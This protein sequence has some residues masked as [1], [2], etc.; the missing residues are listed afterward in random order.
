MKLARGLRTRSYKAAWSHD[1][2]ASTEIPE[3]PELQTNE[4]WRGIM[5]RA[6]AAH[7]DMSQAELARRVGAEM[8]EDAPSQAAI[9]K[10]E[11]G[12][13]TSSRYIKAICVVLAIPLPQHFVDENDRA[14][15]QLGHFLR[16]R[17]PE[18]YK[19]ELARLELQAKRLREANSNPEQTPDSPDRR[20]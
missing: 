2:V 1:F 16:A 20:K 14:W 11:D 10:I 4:E 7:N 5:A 19:L 6:R 8:G 12:K 18:A 3:W 17:D 13:V 15:S 9:S